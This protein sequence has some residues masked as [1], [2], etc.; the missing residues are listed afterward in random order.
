MECGRL[1]ALPHGPIDGACEDAFVVVIHA[2]NEAAVDHHSQVMEPADCGVVI[3]IQVLP[4]V[5]IAKVGGADGLK[6][7]EQA[8]EATCCGFFQEIWSQ[9]RVHCSRRLP[10]SSHATHAVE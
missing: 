4:L 10:Q 3:A 5:V 1:N 2:E 9:H 7:H 8:A 6:A